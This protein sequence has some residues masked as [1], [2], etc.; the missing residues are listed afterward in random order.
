MNIIGLIEMLPASELRIDHL[1][2]CY[3]SHSSYLEQNYS[4]DLF[5]CLSG[6]DFFS[7]SA[8]NRERS[9][10]TFQVVFFET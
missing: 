2:T 10:I 6:P 8:D 1:K 7:S 9:Q 3:F 4:I 5:T